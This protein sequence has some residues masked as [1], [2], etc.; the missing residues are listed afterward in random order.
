ML[1]FRVR[2]IWVYV[3]FY[4]SFKNQYQNTVTCWWDSWRG[5]D[6]KVGKSHPR[7]AMTIYTKCIQW[8]LTHHMC[9]RRAAF[10]FIHLYVLCS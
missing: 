9:H 2:L 3:F 4:I 5:Q 6:N 1:A 10:P 8:M 7:E